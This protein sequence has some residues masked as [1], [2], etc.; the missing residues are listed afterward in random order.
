MHELVDPPDWSSFW[1]EVLLNGQ[2]NSEKL[3]ETGK[4]IE[5]DKAKLG[6][7]KYHDE[8]NF[9][10][11]SIFGGVKRFQE[12]FLRACWKNDTATCQHVSQS[13]QDNEPVA[14]HST[15]EAIINEPAAGPS[16]SVQAPTPVIDEGDSSD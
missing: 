7:R 11:Q 16:S 15:I 12:E 3:G 2:H 9:E 5:I 10:G 8:R 14:G 1:R 6:K 13:V 4:I